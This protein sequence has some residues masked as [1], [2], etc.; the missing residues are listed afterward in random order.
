V[1]RKKLV[2]DRRRVIRRAVPAARKGK[3]GKRPGSESAARGILASRI[4]SVKTEVAREQLQPTK[5]STSDRIIRKPMEIK[6]TKRIVGLQ[7]V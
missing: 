7:E 5:E 2:A 4:A 1:S 6:A 3:K